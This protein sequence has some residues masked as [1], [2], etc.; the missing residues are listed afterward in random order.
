MGRLGARCLLL[1]VIVVG[2]RLPAP[3]AQ[4]ATAALDAAAVALGAASLTSI[5]ITGHGSDYVVG[6]GY[7]GGSPW[8]RFNMPAFSMTIDYATPAMRAER[9][10]AQGEAPPRGGALQPLDGERRLIQFVSGQHV[11]NMTG[12]VPGPAGTGGAVRGESPGIGLHTPTQLEE[13]LLQI[14]LTPHGFIK[15]AKA[16]KAVARTE[17]I[18]GARKAVVSFTTPTQLKLEGILN[19]QHLLERIETWMAHPVLGDTMIEA[20]F[21]GYKHFGGVQFPTHIVHREGGYPVF[22]LTVTDVKPNATAA[23]EV[24]AAVRQAAPPPSAAVEPQKVSDGVWAVGGGS[25]SVAV[26]FSDHIVV[27]D[28]PVDEARSIVV[29]DAVKKVIPN[30][31]IKYIVNTHIHF[32][33]AGGL[34]TYAAEGATIVTQRDNIPYFEQVWANPRT[35]NPDRLARS[36][37]KAT[38]EGVLGS[39][40]MTDGSR[41]LVLY[42][43]AGNMHNS[44]MLMAFLPKERIL[45]EADSFI[46]GRPGGP[47]PAIPNLIQFYEAVQRL[48][49]DV[50]QILPSHGR[51]ATFQDLEQTVAESR[52][53]AR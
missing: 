32:D 51:I 38:F 16:G 30:K 29:I 31:P 4:D 6:Q 17:I 36:G 5:Q 53:A 49:L 27:V 14:W 34:R 48:R 37:G 20:V 10:R 19:E 40:M 23:I 22:D 45:I 26:E 12:D 52:A 28:A 41:E 43:Y 11:W 33:H 42:H 9:T 47:H 39:R 50:D 25:M 13:R 24:P 2:W 18:R 44:G 35:I 3:R 1:V 21:R 15:A 8:P 7:D 46:P